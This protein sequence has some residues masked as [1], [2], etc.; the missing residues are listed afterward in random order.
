MFVVYLNPFKLN[1]D[2]YNTLGEHLL[3]YLLI[4]YWFATENWHSEYLLYHLSTIL[5]GMAFGLSVHE[6]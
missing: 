3:I 5:M 2:K 4:L 6:N 1:D